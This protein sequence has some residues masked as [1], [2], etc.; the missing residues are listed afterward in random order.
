MV[1]K[2]FVHV[3]GYNGTA[4]LVLDVGLNNGSTLTT[5]LACFC[6]LQSRLMKRLSIRIERCRFF[7]LRV[8]KATRIPIN[9]V[10]IFIMKAMRIAPFKSPGA[11]DSIGAFV[12]ENVEM[13]AMMTANP[14]APPICCPV[15]TIEDARPC[16]FISI[17]VLPAIY[18]VVNTKA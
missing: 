17:F 5:G 9:V 11:I 8:T 1:L 12:P 10:T 6:G 14:I 18:I 16:S 13:T 2:V 15:D 7:C 4:G 3:R